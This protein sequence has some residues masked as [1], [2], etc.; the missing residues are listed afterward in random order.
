MLDVTK[1][2]FLCGV[3]KGA[4]Q[5]AKAVLHN[6]KAV[7]YLMYIFALVKLEKFFFKSLYQSW[8]LDVVSSFGMYN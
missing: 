3:A 7:T 6:A 2:F 4:L 1:P 8:T 5:T